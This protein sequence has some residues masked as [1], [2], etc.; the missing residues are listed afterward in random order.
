MAD[1]CAHSAWRFIRNTNDPK[2]VKLYATALAQLHLEHSGTEPAGI[3]HF[4]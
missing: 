4:S 3:R 2:S 1:W